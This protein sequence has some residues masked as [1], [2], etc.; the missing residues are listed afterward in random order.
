MRRAIL[1][2]SFVV[3]TSPLHG[4]NV[5]VHQTQLTTMSPAAVFEKCKKIV[6]TAC[7]VFRDA[8]LTCMC[9][10]KHGR[11][12]P[13]VS[14]AAQPQTYTSS[15]AYVA[16]ELTHILDFSMAMR[17]HAEDLEDRAFASRA[18]CETF[19]DRAE[20]QFVDVLRDYVRASTW[21]RDHRTADR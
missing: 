12:A 6:D 18:A 3:A 14:I 10:F 16:H 9:D 13:T 5:N 15:P 1:A 4:F 17:K 21:L 7:T 19:A 11:W 20:E 2:I 8:Q